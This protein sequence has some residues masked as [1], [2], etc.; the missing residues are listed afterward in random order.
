M[1]RQHINFFCSPE[2]DKLLWCTP[3]V[4]ARDYPEPA[5][6]AG[7]RVSTDHASPP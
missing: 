7:H 3:P 5:R 1:T 2:A 6:T 4:A